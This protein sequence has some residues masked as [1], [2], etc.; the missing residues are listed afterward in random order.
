MNIL[1]SK[2]NPFLVLG[3]IVLLMTIAHFIIRRIDT[4]I[5]Q[6]FNEFK[7]TYTF[8]E[9]LSKHCENCEFYNKIYNTCENDAS[10][11]YLSEY[12]IFECER[13]KASKR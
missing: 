1:L 3:I 2:M 6:E 13:E 8:P 7:K 10:F 4:E 11:G 9:P 12:T 5:R